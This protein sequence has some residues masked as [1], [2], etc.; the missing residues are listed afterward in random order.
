MVITVAQKP[1]FTDEVV[2]RQRCREQLGQPPTA[3]RPILV[4]RDK[5]QR[6]KRRRF[7]KA[8]V[9]PCA[10][11]ERPEEDCS[12]PA[13]LSA[14]TLSQWMHARSRARAQFTTRRRQTTNTHR[15]RLF[16]RR[17]MGMPYSTA[18]RSTARFREVHDGYDRLG[19]GTAMLKVAEADARSS[20]FFVDRRRA[21]DSR[22]SRLTASGRA[23]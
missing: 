4:K 14:L 7:H 21:R 15:S 6:V 11:K 5:A 2:S 12:A 13:P 18:G 19:R 8:C 1:R 23:S 22:L 9:V 17:Q 3:P 16:G 10:V 20:A